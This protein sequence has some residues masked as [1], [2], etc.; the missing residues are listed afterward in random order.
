MERTLS[1]VLDDEG[2]VSLTLMQDEANKID[3]FTTKKFED[4]EQIRDYFKDEIEKF[5]KEKKSY[6]DAISKRLGKKYRGRIVI[7]EV[8]NKDNNLVFHERRVLY[9]KHFK[10]FKEI[11]KNKNVMLRFL[12]LEEVGRTKYGYPM[13]APEFLRREIRFSDFRV[14]S[15][16]ELIRK[17]IKRSKCF[18]DILRI[19]IKSYNTE[20]EFNPSLETID[21]MYKRLQK[22]EQSLDVLPTRE[23]GIKKINEELYVNIDGVLYPIEEIPFDLDTLKDTDYVPDGLGYGKRIR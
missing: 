18:F 15:R 3:E 8:Q 21:S 2:K 22:K 13:L 14:K 7:L 19:M 4:S 16:V 17:E 6:I 5:L 1:L 23:N 10:V 11:I 20:R 12:K 9:K